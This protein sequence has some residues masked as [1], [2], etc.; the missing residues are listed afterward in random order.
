MG[1]KPHTEAGFPVPT[2]GDGGIWEDPDE[3]GDRNTLSFKETV[4]VS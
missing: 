4:L 2:F 3:N 1:Q